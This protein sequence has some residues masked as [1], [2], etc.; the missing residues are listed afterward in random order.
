MVKGNE[1]IIIVGSLIFLVVVALGFLFLS[2]GDYG[3]GSGDLGGGSGSGSSG[4]SGGGDG[5]LGDGGVGNGGGFGGEDLEKNFCPEERGSGICIEIYQPVCGWN[6]EGVNCFA[7]PCAS[8]Y[9]N[10]CFACADE[11]VAYWT[12]GECPPVS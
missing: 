9:S 2:D 5:G 6:G 10:S 11:N 4:G 8:T 1:G 12:E 7:F 3:V